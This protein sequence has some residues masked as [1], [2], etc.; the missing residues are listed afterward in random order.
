MHALMYDRGDS[1]RSSSDRNFLRSKDQDFSP[2]IAARCTT[3]LSKYGSVVLWQL[4]L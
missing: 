4:L 2:Q 1:K 3:F